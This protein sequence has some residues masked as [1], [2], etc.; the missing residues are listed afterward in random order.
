MFIMNDLNQITEIEQKTFGPGGVNK[1]TL[2]SLE[3]SFKE[4]L[5]IIKEEDNVLAYLGW[6]KHK[7]DK[8]P[9]YNH[10]CLRTHDRNGKLAYI[11]IITVKK[12]YRNKGLGSKLLRILEKL[13]MRQKC[14]KL[15]CPVNKKH[16]YLDKGVLHFWKKNDFEITGE[17]DWKIAEGKQIPSFIFTKELINI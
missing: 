3:K 8:F 5:I 1:K 11:S 16:P 15:Y 17:V 9:P 6:E 4:G 10:D 7:K 12:E 13:A 14:T 2:L